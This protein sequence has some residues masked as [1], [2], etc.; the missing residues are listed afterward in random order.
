MKT[1]PTALMVGTDL[2]SPRARRPF[3]GATGIRQIRIAE[4]LNCDDACPTAGRPE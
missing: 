1:D 3:T 4:A 2:P